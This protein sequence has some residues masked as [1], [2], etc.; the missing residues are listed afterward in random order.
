VVKTLEGEVMAKE[1]AQMTT[2]KV[3]LTSANPEFDDR[4]IA[5]KD[6]QWIARIVWASQ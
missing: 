1:L 6:V 3:V 2:S 4:T 5:R